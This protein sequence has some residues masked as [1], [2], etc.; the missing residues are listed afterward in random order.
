MAFDLLSCTGACLVTSV[1]LFGFAR[2]KTKRRSASARTTRARR[3]AGATLDAVAAWS[4][5]RRR[6]ELLFQLALLRADDLSAAELEASPFGHLIEGVA[7]AEARLRLMRERARARPKDAKS[8]LLWASTRNEILH[9]KEPACFKVAPEAIDALRSVNTSGPQLKAAVVPEFLMAELQGRNCRNVRLAETHP[10]IFEVCGNWLIR[11]NPYYFDYE[12]FPKDLKK[13]KDDPRGFAIIAWWIHPALQKSSRHFNDEVEP[14]RLRA[15]P[16]STSS[17]SMG[18]VLSA[19]GDGS[20]HA[21]VADLMSDG[22][23]YVCTALDF[24]RS[25]IA[26]LKA[27]RAA[28]RS[29]MQRVYGVEDLED[30]DLVFH[31]KPVRKSNSKYLTAHLHIFYKAG[32]DAECFTKSHTLS[33]V[34][35]ELETKGC[36]TIDTPLYIYS[37]GGG[38][39][40]CSELYGDE[41]TRELTEEGQIYG[42]ELEGGTTNAAAFYQKVT[43]V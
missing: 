33:S 18:R 9:S 15:P 7:K 27:L 25:D 8:P 1:L 38:S 12:E 40:N 35:A 32:R 42:G 37:N 17:A 23:R 43:E 34:I 29:H 2:H 10:E 6:E 11:P 4:P 24:D 39:M 13:A 22:S 26:E 5:E 36:V 31:L 21:R 19:T 20:S 14:L 16:P 30:D 28:A 41:T 3:L